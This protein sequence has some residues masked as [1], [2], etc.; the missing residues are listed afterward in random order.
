MRASSRI[1]WFVFYYYYIDSAA[2]ERRTISD[3]DIIVCERN[4]HFSTGVGGVGPRVG[5]GERVVLM[6]LKLQR[7]RLQVENLCYGGTLPSLSSLTV[8]GTTSISFGIRHLQLVP[9]L[10]TTLGI[11]IFVLLV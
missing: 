5:A 4:S 9:R 3:G 7:N 1:L 6:F 10:S 2:Y 11:K 8:Y